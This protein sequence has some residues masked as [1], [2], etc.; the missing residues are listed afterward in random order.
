MGQENTFFLLMYWCTDAN[1]RFHS[2][3]VVINHHS[4]KQISHFCR[5]LSKRLILSVNPITQIRNS[6][7]LLRLL[8]ISNFLSTWYKT[9]DQPLDYVLLTLHFVVPVSNITVKLILGSYLASWII[10]SVVDADSG[11][12]MLCMTSALYD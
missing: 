4:D 3:C 2:L 8:P 1:S 7:G 10:A 11:F 5:P 9:P 12:C 6:H